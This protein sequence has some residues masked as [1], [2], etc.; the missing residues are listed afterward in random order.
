MNTTSLL[1]LDRNHIWHPYTSMDHPLPCFPVASAEGVEIT[2]E[3]GEKL[4]DGMSSWWAAIHGYQHP[5]LNQAIQNQIQKMSHVMFGGLTHRPAVELATQLLKI[6]P[7]AL[8]KIFYSD[9]GSVA[10]EVALK[11]A[12]QYQMSRGRSTRTKFATVRN[13]YHGDTWHAMGVCDPDTG[14]HSI[15]KDRLAPTLFAPSPKVSFFETWDT[16]DFKP[17]EQLILSN[18]EEVAAVI[19]EPIVQGAGGMRFYHPQY[20]VELHRLCQQHDILLIFDEIATG[21]GRTGKMF[22]LEHAGVVPDILCLGKAITGG[23]M[24]FATTMT[25]VEVATT[26]SQGTPGVIMHGPTFMGNPLACAVA[27][28]S[29]EIIMQKET[30]TKVKTLEQ[31]LIQ[32]L[33]PFKA[34]E[35][36]DDVRVLGAI[37]VIEMKEAVDMQML[38][39]SFVKHGIW[40]RPFGK[41]IYMMPPYIMSSKALSQLIKGLKQSISEVYHI[42]I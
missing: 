16:S 22:A 17:M 24:S 2:L 26:I 27:T 37:G 41:L 36:V 7:D 34:L 31:Q 28:Q 5:Q 30:L 39:Q 20:L 1:E 38:Q 33:A 21:F 35:I 14:M 11:M 9:S 19:L 42:D 8:Q 13:G 3:T 18:H 6:T 29:L 4:I 32:E 12:L 10:V 15:Y 23:M 40:L 25:T